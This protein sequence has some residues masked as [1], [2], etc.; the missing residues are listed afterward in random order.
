MRYFLILIIAFPLFLNAQSGKSKPKFSYAR[1]TMF[2]YFGYNRSWY[3]KSKINFIGPGYDFTLAGS[4]ATDSPSHLG[5]AGYFNPNKMTVQQ[6]NLRLGY[7]FK[8]HFAISFGYDHLKYLFADQNQVLLSGTINPGVDTVTNWSGTYNNEAVTTDR[9]TFHYENA[10]GLN[11]LRLEL[12][13]TDQWFKAGKNDLFAFSTNLGLGLG[14][15]L[16]YNDFVFA[17]KREEATSS[18]SGIGVSAHAGLRFE[19]FRHVFI[20]TNFSGGF[21]DQL[22]VRNSL[23][24]Q[25]AYTKQKFGYTSF[26]TSLGFLLYIRPTN[27]CNS[28]PHW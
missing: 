2:G 15:L 6:Y 5:I 9:N 28:C 18:M 20:Q 13:R 14:A 1:G 4:K 17:G 24:E 16:S 25:N 23:M 19:F 12:T 21:M 10:N 7:Y 11:Y 27:D 22:H 26:D 3:S 8:N